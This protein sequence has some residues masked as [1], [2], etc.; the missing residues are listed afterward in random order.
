MRTL[1]VFEYGQIEGLTPAEKNL[2]DQLRGPRNESL[3]EVGWRETRATSFVG[4]VQ[5]PQT[6]L[7]VLPKMYRHEDAKECEAT[8]NLLFLLSYTRKLDV[9]EP[10][11][12]RLTAQ[13]APFSEIL[14][15]IFA[16]RLWN[17][18]HREILRGYVT[19]EDRLDVLKGRWLVAAQADRPDGW[20]RDRFD[21][22]YDEFTE[23]NLPNQLFKATVHRLSRWAQW[24][25]TRRRLTQLRAVFTDVADVTPQ[26]HDF[27][28]AANPD[29]GCRGRHR[30]NEGHL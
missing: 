6:T 8:A 12:S 9:T 15:W 29:I 10:E 22:A 3:F 24:T 18:V 20:R 19:I 17:A 30:A 4:V 28:Q 26:P 11:I 25:D 21:V 2:L 14:F 13:H 27:D 5:L 16:H 23:D 1:S 7:Q